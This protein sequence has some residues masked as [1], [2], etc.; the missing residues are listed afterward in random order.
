MSL[1]PNTDSRRYPAHKTSL[2]LSSPAD[3]FMSHPAIK[4]Q[5]PPRHSP[6]KK[7]GLSQP[8]HNRFKHSSIPSTQT[9]LF[10]M[11]D[12]TGGTSAI[13]T[14]HPAHFHRH[15]RPY[16]IPP[17]PRPANASAVH[18]LQCPTDHRPP[19]HHFDKPDTNKKRKPLASTRGFL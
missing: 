6:L 13:F 4:K 9:L 12:T 16:A 19:L 7:N 8:T 3:T 18:F 11:G 2:C 14:E 5:L 17:P 1:L 15:N 10:N